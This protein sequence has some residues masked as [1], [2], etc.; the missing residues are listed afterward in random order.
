MLSLHSK[1]DNTKNNNHHN[2]G[3]LTRTVG[4]V[5]ASK[6]WIVDWRVDVGITSARPCRRGQGYTPTPPEKGGLD[7]KLTLHYYSRQ[8]RASSRYGLGLSWWVEGCC[9]GCL[10][11]AWS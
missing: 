11:L 10:R 3:S 7:E 8:H 5:T 2:G 4:G 1:S 9:S 6:L